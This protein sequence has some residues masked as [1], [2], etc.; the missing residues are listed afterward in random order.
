MAAI[1][2]I[3]SV[4][5][6]VTG[7]IQA[8]Q[9]RKMAEN[10][11]IP[12]YEIPESVKKATALAARG[13][14]TFE[15]PGQDQ[16]IQGIEAQEASLLNNATTAATSSPNLLSAM[17]GAA[18]AGMGTR[19]DIGAQAARDYESR[20]QAYETSLLNLGTYEERKRLDEIG[21][22]ERAAAAAAALMQSGRQNMF[23]GL[24]N[25]AGIGANLA[26]MK[27]GDV[28]GNMTGQD[29]PMIADASGTSYGLTGYS[30]SGMGGVSAQKI[31]LQEYIN[32]LLN[33]K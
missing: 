8:R 7:I 12:E 31:A 14:G 25:L 24:N 10:V 22:G 3:P 32:E 29:T 16:I 26:G 6:G 19:L 9:G 23:A 11:V 27:S 1:S 17:V 15:M 21:R 18:S 2:A 30:G 20:K 28:T 33:K 13:V 4:V 5:Q